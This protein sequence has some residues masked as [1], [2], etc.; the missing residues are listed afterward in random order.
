[1]RQEGYN[2]YALDA[3]AHGNSTGT[4]HLLPDYVEAAYQLTQKHQI[5]H[6]I[7]HSM[8]GMAYFTYSTNT[9]TPLFAHL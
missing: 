1:M 3:P 5:K 9:K 8:G 4:Y 2:I 7:G 6:L